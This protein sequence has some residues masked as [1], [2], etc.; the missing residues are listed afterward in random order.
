MTNILAK[1]MISIDDGKV[2]V[3]LFFEM[4]ENDGRACIY[5]A[6]VSVD[7]NNILMNIEFPILDVE[8]MII[9]KDNG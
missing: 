9:S 6:F 3:L 2:K 4:I 7:T 8:R 1:E 5:G